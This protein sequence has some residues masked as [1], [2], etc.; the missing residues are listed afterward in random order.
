M[1]PKHGTNECAIVSAGGA[2]DAHTLQCRASLGT[3]DIGAG[4]PDHKDTKHDILRRVLLLSGF[5]AI[6]EDASGNF[7]KV[8][9]SD[10]SNIRAKSCLAGH[11]YMR[12]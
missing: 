7:G 1:G 4:F 5:Q 10:G 8:F 12:L 3:S 11:L 6:C 9:L 2:A